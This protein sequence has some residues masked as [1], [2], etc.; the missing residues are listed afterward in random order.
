MSVDVANT[1][2]RGAKWRPAV[3]TGLLV[4]A[5]TM[6]MLPLFLLGALGPRLVDQ[7]HVAAW[8]LGALVSAGFGVAAV[9]SL[10]IGP[11]VTALG[12]RRCLIAMFVI[13]AI[14]LGLFAAAPSYPV[15]VV[16]VAVSGLAQALANPAT[17][18]LIAARI[19]PARRGSVAGWKQSG[20]QFG[21]FLAGLPLAAVASATTWRA[22]VA[23]IAV[24]ALCA[25][26][27]SLLI[28][29]DTVPLRLP[30]LRFAH[31]RG[32][33]GW[34]CGYSV[35]LGAGVSA[36][37]TYIALYAAR[38]LAMS[39]PAAS[40][41]VAVLGVAGIAGR[42]GWTRRAAGAGNSGALLGPLAFGATIA[43]ALIGLAG[44]LEVWPVWLGVLGIGG[45][46]VAANAVSMM[47]VIAMAPPD[48]VGPDSAVVSA[49]F[50][51]GFVIGPTAFGVLAG[52]G[53]GGYDLAWLAVAVAFLAAAAVA[54]RWQRRVAGSR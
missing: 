18:Q 21:A 31:A 22:A 5:M 42:V 54:W 43:A 32:D 33:A 26:G 1:D 10:M 12:A 40:A 53:S 41:L 2:A 15:L 30:P 52:S 3:L 25:A 50:F 35:L 39:A 36:I 49:G 37:N 9:V 8:A 45:C 6:S 51:A 46:A 38:H 48:R 11:M 19:S 27:M 17:N 44:R 4:T 23:L 13:S 34:L 7:F 16:A 20:V 28:A 24:V 14:A 47:T 29:K